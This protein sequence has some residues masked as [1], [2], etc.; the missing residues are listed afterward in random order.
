MSRH[1][2]DASA[3]IA[4]LDKEPG[5]ERM[6]DLMEKAGE[7]RATLLMTAVN[8]GEVLYTVENARGVEIREK[9]ERILASHPIEMVEVGQDLAKRAAELKSTRKLPY[10]DCFAAA[11]AAD[12]KAVLVTCDKDFQRVEKEIKIDWLG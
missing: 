2:L 7:G 10:V 4:Y 3:V 5:H 12:R 8:W 6:V 11:L 1:V 9:V